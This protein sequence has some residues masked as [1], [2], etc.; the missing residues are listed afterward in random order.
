MRWL[1]KA[2]VSILESLTKG[3]ERVAK[4]E[5]RYIFFVP[6]STLPS[7]SLAKDKQALR[8]LSK[9]G[10]LNHP[11]FFASAHSIETREGTHKSGTIALSHYGLNT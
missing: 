1:V 11:L 8:R 3:P 4:D 10:N 6:G 5:W 7:W 2:I 9:R